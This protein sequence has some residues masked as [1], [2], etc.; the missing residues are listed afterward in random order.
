[1]AVAGAS[2]R[3]QKTERINRA[4]ALEPAGNASGLVTLA[5]NESEWTDADAA[6]DT[7]ATPT[8]TAV[9]VPVVAKKISVLPRAPK[10]RSISLG[11][12]LDT[13][14]P[15]KA[16]VN[17]LEALFARYAAA[18]ESARSR[19]E[20]GMRVV[21]LN[22]LFA[23][24]RLS[25]NGGVTDTRM[26]LAGAAN[27]IRVYRQQQAAI[28]KAYQDTVVSMARQH[29][30]SPKKVRQWYSRLPKKEAPTLELLSG[31]LVTSIDSL[32]SVLAAQ[33]GAYKLRGTAIAFEDPT[34]GQAY[35]SLRRRVKE[36]IDAAIAAGGATSPGATGLL[37]RAIGTTSLP[38]ET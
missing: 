1:V 32:L 36:Q 30:W 14:T 19:L 21:R 34:A 37:L 23:P 9:T 20:T 27:F 22:Q 38:R 4:Q 7:I 2:T 31:S 13:R 12:A 25:P 6:A 3:S 8:D 5:S 15:Q 10:L 11:E 28:E 17:S 24:A 35:G 33:A 18:H 29:G 16:D 26:S